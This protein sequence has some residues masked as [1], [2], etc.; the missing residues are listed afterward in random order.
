M[1][2]VYNINRFDGAKHLTGTYTAMCLP[3]AQSI[4][5]KWMELDKQTLAEKHGATDITTSYTY[6]SGTITYYSEE[7]FQEEVTYK[8]VCNLITSVI[9]ENTFK[10]SDPF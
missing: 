7:G 4:L 1:I 6:D 2:Q 3:T 9:N 5:H 10:D 8:I